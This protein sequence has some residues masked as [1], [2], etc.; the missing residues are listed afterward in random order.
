MVSSVPLADQVSA[1]LP[2]RKVYPPQEG[3]QFNRKRNSEKANI[4]YGVSY[5]RVVIRRL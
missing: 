2:A 1:P 4:E 3:G 5:E